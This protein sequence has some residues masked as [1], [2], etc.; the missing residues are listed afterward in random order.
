MRLPSAALFHRARETMISNASATQKAR[1]KI[2]RLLFFYVT[3]FPFV[4]WPAQQDRVL[5]LGDIAGLPGEQV[6]V[7]VWLSE[8]LGVAGVDLAVQFDP[9]LFSVEAVATT[10][11]TGGMMIYHG[12]PQPGRLA[13]SM[14]QAEAL[15]LSGPGRIARITVRIANCAP[16]NGCDML[17]LRMARWYDEQCVRHEVLA[18][19]GLVTFSANA[20]LHAP[21]VL[22]LGGAAGAPGSFVTFDLWLSCGRTVGG[23]H[24]GLGYDTAVLSFVRAV[25]TADTAQWV[26]TADNDPVGGYLTLNLTGSKELT[27]MSAVCPVRV[28]FQ[29]L[30]C[31]VGPLRRRV[32]LSGTL[33][34]NTENL[35]FVHEALDGDVCVSCA[36]ATLTVR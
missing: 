31:V 29:V 35:R 22:S 8:L 5:K 30:P 12:F 2:L 23:L 18:D 28:T 24:A 27:A 17:A 16:L 1:A 10:T 25:L 34:R 15:A 21:L 11:E 19:H 7:D 14:A 26:C 13:I 4:A 20:P 32:S 33:I 6:V 3:V 9:L 36:V